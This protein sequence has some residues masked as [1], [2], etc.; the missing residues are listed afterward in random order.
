MSKKPAPLW[1]RILARILLLFPE[2]WLQPL[3][4]GKV[5]YRKK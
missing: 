1:A 3:A 5:T 2:R 4:R